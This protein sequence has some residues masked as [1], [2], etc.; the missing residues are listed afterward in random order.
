MGGGWTVMQRRQYGTV[1]F[2][3]NWNDYSNGF[4]HLKTEF[5]FGNENIHD[6]TKASV[7]PK[8]STLLINMIIRGKAV[9]VFAKYSS[10]SVGNA[11]SKYVLD[12]TGFSGNASNTNMGMQNKMKFSTFDQDNDKWGRNC[13][14]RYKG[15][16]WYNSCFVVN[17][18]APYYI[19]DFKYNMVWNLRAQPTEFLSFVEMKIR[20]NH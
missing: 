12:I 10:F 8:K 2:N 20:R 1:D 16:W 9:P 17:L 4:G 15:G 11:A 7:A 19:P 3:R 18:N 5:W 14:S 6:L 13:A